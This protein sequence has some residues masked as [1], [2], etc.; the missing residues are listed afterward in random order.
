MTKNEIAL[1][2][3]IYLI[4]NRPNFNG[5]LVNPNIKLGI[6]RHAVLTIALVMFLPSKTVFCAPLMI[7]ASPAGSLILLQTSFL[8]LVFLHQQFLC[9]IVFAHPC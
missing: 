3:K 5:T 1:M 7:S 4:F 6:Q 2:G 8:S 9:Y